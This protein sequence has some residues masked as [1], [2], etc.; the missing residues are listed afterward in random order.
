VTAPEL[1][2]AIESAGGVL[3]LSGNRIR[4]ELPEDAA[5][6]V[7]VL[8]KHREEVIRVLQERERPAHCCVHG[9]MTTWWARA[10]GAWVCGRCH[11]GPFAGSVEL[12]KSGPPSMPEGVT[13]L[14]YVPKC[15]PVAIETW[16]I[17]NDVPQ[18]IRTTIAQLEAALRGDCLGS[19]N[20][21]VRTLVE[22]LE[23][24]GVRVEVARPN[25]KGD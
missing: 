24:V 3:S 16:A 4:Y 11:P 15:P 10:D 25:S 9:P 5:A 23:Q 21:P 17:V 2:H 8:R 14:D 6:L 20:W 19:G 7:E 1:I 12:N 18:F 22:R 13:L